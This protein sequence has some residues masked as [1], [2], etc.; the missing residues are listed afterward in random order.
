MNYTLQHFRA[1]TIV[2]VEAGDEIK[3]NSLLRMLNAFNVCFGGLLIS[4]IGEIEGTAGEKKLHGIS[5]SFSGGDLSIIQEKIAAL[6]LML[7][8]SGV[9]RPDFEFSTYEAEE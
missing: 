5:L 6:S 8:I 3:I 7:H 2:F 1:D 9:Q 4:E